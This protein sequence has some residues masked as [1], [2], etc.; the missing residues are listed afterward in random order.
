MVS[1]VNQFH[2]AE[3]L[4]SEGDAKAAVKIAKRMRKPGLTHAN[5]VLRVASLLWRCGAESDCARY[6]VRASERFPQHTTIA[7]EGAKR[8]LETKRFPEALML[9]ERGISTE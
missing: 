4:L 2:L 7:D 8:C 9:S 6:L 1:D 5:S 3:R